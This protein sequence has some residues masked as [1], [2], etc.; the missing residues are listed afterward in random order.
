MAKTKKEI[1]QDYLKRTGYS[2]N[3]KYNKE[4]TKVFPIRLVANTEQDIIQQLDSV[5][6]KSGYVKA[7]IREDIARREKGEK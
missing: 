7:L 4:K 6:N 5:E 2:A 1:Q 3:K